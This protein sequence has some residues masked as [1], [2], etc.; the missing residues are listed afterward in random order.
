[1]QE[2]K[3][4][5]DYD[6]FKVGTCW[7]CTSP[8]FKITYIIEV[9]KSPSNGGRYLDVKEIMHDPYVR[10]TSNIR[11][12]HVEGFVINEMENVVQITKDQ[13]EML[14]DLANEPRN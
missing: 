12:S 11:Y 7:R 5:I 3:S 8:Y 13:F 1:M 9:Q 4:L 10:S 2:T 6:R 14:W